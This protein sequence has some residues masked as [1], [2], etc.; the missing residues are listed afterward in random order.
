[1]AN[2][3]KQ[4][5]TEN[6]ASLF[7]AILDATP[8]LVF[9]KNK[10]FE[11]IAHNKAFA[12]LVGCPK[13]DLTG[14]LDE[15][16]FSNEASVKKIRALDKHIFETAET[17]CNLETT[18]TPE[19]KI[20]KVDTLTAIA[21]RRKCD[22]YLLSQWNS[23]QRNQSNILIAMVDVDQFKLYND[24]YGH[25]QGDNALSLVAKALSD[26]LHRS[27]DFVARYGGEEF[28]IVLTDTTKSGAQTVIDNC[29]KAVRELEI[30]H[31]SSHHGVVTISVGAVGCKPSVALP[32]QAIKQADDLLYQAKEAGRDQV[33]WG[34]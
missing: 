17:V 29:C 33:C 28:M 6:L 26:Q 2:R 23:A 31:R 25:D 18:V 30:E 5:H 16:I 22:Q 3:S 4:E 27:R 34:A 10:N 21:N 32:K 1:M 8:D 9:A 19:G 7:Y 24:E 11:Y 15:E 14:K 12:S 13:Q 20:A